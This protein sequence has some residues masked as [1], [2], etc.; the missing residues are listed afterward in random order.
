M[1][2]CQARAKAMSFWFSERPYVRTTR[3]GV[4]RGRHCAHGYVYC[5]THV[6][7][8]HHIHRKRKRRRRRGSYGSGVFSSWLLDFSADMTLGLVSR[9]RRSQQGSQEGVCIRDSA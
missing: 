9:N 4:D 2:A 8:P 1:L 7:E 6:H 3:K 5:Y